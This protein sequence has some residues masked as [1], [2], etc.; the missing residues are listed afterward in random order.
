[1]LIGMLVSFVCALVSD[2]MFQMA[3]ALSAL[4]LLVVENLGRGGGEK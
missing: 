3:L 1:M 2:T 4:G